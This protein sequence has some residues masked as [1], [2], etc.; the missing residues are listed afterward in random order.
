M[1]Y[2]SSEFREYVFLDTHGFSEIECL[3]RL[4]ELILAREA[5]NKLIDDSCYI[6]ETKIVTETHKKKMIEDRDIVI[7]CTC[8]CKTMLV[9]DFNSLLKNA[10]LRIHKWEIDKS[11]TL[12]DWIVDCINQPIS[13]TQEKIILLTF[14]YAKEDKGKMTG[15]IVYFN[16]YIRS[17]K[18]KCFRV[19]TDKI[20]Q[21]IE[22][23]GK[24]NYANVVENTE[25]YFDK[26][27]N[28]IIK[29]IKI[30]K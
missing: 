28:E 26:T 11:P 22:R 9:N 18:A 27:I 15:V 6:L 20:P 19:I 29:T 23:I 24:S 21:I 25:E 5:I 10:F 14:E 12:L 30:Q 17:V 8:K 16:N 2:L 7:D 3:T 13:D 4:K 1:S